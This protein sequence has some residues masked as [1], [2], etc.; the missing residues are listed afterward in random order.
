MVVRARLIRVLPPPP[1]LW[2]PLVPGS[3]GAR[4]ELGGAVGTEKCAPSSH[5]PPA[6]SYWK[7]QM[8]MDPKHNTQNTLPCFL[9]A[10]CK[11]K[12]GSSWGLTFS[13]V[14]TTSAP[15]RAWQKVKESVTAIVDSSETEEREPPHVPSTCTGEGRPTPAPTQVCV[16]APSHVT[17][18]CTTGGASHTHL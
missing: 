18:Q 7:E 11:L 1:L 15:H 17:Q 3:P 8:Q 12:L 16:C 5:H 2:H 9:G 14:Q 13:L 6:L 4:G 10:C